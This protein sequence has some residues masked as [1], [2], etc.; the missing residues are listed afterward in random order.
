MYI[1]GIQAGGRHGRG[2][3]LFVGFGSAYTAST[4]LA[5]TGLVG[6]FAIFIHNQGIIST[7]RTGALV[8][9]PQGC[10][11]LRT[12]RA[13][14]GVFLADYITKIFPCKVVFFTNKVI[15]KGS[16]KSRKRNTT[17]T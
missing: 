7:T 3:V 16:G 4:G 14:L 5:A 11:T 13:G 6:D 17:H 2:V 9:F 15:T 10:T 1:H 12:G 8:D